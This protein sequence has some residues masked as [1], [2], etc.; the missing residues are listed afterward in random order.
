MQVIDY[1]HLKYFIFSHT[2]HENQT[3]SVLVLGYWLNWFM[4]KL[5]PYIALQINNGL[6]LRFLKKHTGH[7]EK[8]D[9]CEA[10]LHEQDNNIESGLTR[11][12]M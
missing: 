8:I 7:D 1:K 10:F 3:D 12:W 5:N 4:K 9:D 11:P 2:T 6:I